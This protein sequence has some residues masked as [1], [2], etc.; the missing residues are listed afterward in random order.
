M[1]STPS[2]NW[3]YPTSVRFGAGRI[4]ELGSCAAIVG[5]KRPLLVTDPGL[6][7]LPMT[8]AALDVR[9]LWQQHF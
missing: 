1:T 4:K 6:A 7:K 5:M 2:A 9:E 8:E 3:S